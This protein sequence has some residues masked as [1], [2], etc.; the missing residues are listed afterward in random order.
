[1]LQIS[2]PQYTAFHLSKRIGAGNLLETAQMIKQSFL[3]MAVEGVLIFND[4]DGQ[5]TDLDLRGTAKEVQQ[6][7]SESDQWQQSVPTQA[8]PEAPRGP[9]RPKLGV[10]AREVTLLPRHWEWLNSQTGGASVALRKL[11]DD[12]RRANSGR[13]SIRLAQEAS[14]RMMSAA[15]SSEATFEEASRALFAGDSERFTHLIEKWPVDLKT[16][17]HKLASPA[18]AQVA[19][20]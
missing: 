7:L 13:D 1:M 11:V 2:Q 17:L 5:L 15:L 8:E 6:R 4:A 9:G 19:T 18:F 3:S 20:M 14:Y 16:Y 10:V 12:A